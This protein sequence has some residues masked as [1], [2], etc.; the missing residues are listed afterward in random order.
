MAQVTPVKYSYTEIQYELWRGPI[1]TRIV[2]RTRCSSIIPSAKR[3]LVYVLIST[4]LP[5]QRLPTYLLLLLIIHL[6]NAII[7]N[8]VI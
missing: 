5:T 6:H 2:P 8:I 7:V 3:E 1:A 4:Y